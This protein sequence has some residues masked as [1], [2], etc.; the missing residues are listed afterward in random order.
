MFIEAFWVAQATMSFRSQ[1]P[2]NV[3][4]SPDASLLAV[5]FPHHVS[6]YDPLTIISQCI[7]A[8]PEF[9]EISSCH[10]VDH[11]GRYLLVRAERNLAIWDLILQRGKHSSHEVKS[12]HQI[13]Q[14]LG[15]GRTSFPLRLPYQ[16]RHMTSLLSCLVWENVAVWW[17]TTASL[18]SHWKSEV[19][20]LHYA[21][22]HCVHRNSR[23]LQMIGV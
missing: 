9:A 6:L 3:A 21:T 18:R 10:F 22:S 12:S 8:T 13:S 4:W 1:R 15:V 7:V 17:F 2:L 19:C 5:A 20:P 11:T 23:V 16:I 14:Y